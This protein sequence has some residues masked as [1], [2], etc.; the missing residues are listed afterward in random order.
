M[1]LSPSLLAAAAAAAFV[2]SAPPALKHNFLHAA[3]R[4]QPRRAA[5]TPLMA[6]AFSFG[7]S[8]QNKNQPSEEVLAAYRLLGIAEDATYDETTRAYETLVEKYKDNPKRKIQIDV[9][10]DKVFEEQLR[11]RMSG[12]L[13][14]VVAE[15]PWDRKPEPRRLIKL[16]S[17][18]EE[19][20]ELPTREYFL[21]N[22]AV[23]SVIGLI[24]M[25]AASLASTSITL[26]LAISIFLLYNRGV[27]PDA[28]MS[29]MRTIKRKPVALT[30]GLTFLFAAIGGAIGS[31]LMGIFRY[32]APEALI[33][34]GVSS[35]LCF[36]C[37]IFKV[38]DD[39]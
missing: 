14:P 21:K 11:R 24:P 31:V 32:V 39:V 3:Q 1:S 38:R 17:W 5:A 9:A 16:P 33:S 8:A 19:F 12:S 13:K 7:K 26:S 28:G 29:E 6:G 18:A 30:V 36:A 15:S 20:A 27:P 25:L 23:F 37:S 4:G 35:A 10:K 34:F 22:L 2:S